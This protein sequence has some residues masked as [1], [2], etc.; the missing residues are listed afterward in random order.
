M[1]GD[2]PVCGP[3]LRLALTTCA[4]VT[5]SAVDIPPPMDRFDGKVQAS[6]DGVVVTACQDG[7][8]AAAA[9]MR[10]G[11]LLLAIDGWRVQDV[12]EVM[13]ALRRTADPPLLGHVALLRDG[14]LVEVDL[15]G[16]AAAG[17][18]GAALVVAKLEV[19][20]GKR[21]HDL[22]VQLSS[23]EAD[24][25]DH[26]P[27]RASHA[28]REW[29][30]AR[31]G[32]PGELGWAR[33]FADDFLRI[34]HGE[35]ALA[36]TAVAMPVPLLARLDR[37][38]HAIGAARGPHGG[39]PDPAALGED[40]RFVAE[41]YPFPWTPM[42]AM[43]RIA[44]QDAALAE[45]LASEREDP[46]GSGEERARQ[47]QGVVNQLAIKSPQDYLGEV[48]ASLM[49]ELHHGGWPYRSVL[50][51]AEQDRTRMVDWLRAQLAGPRAGDDL[52]SYALLGPLAVDGKIDE[53]A[54]IIA[55]LDSR[56][57]YLA[58]RALRMVRNAASTRNPAALPQ[59]DA[60][61]SQ[62]RARAAPTAIAAYDYCLKRSR[63][64]SQAVAQ[65]LDYNERFGV[66]ALF[67]MRPDLVCQSLLPD[68]AA[69]SGARWESALMCR[70]ICRLA[71]S[72][73]ADPALTDAEQAREL[74]EQARQAG[75]GCSMP[76][77]AR[78]SPPAGRARAT[79]PRRSAGWPRRSPCRA[80]RPITPRPWA[81]G[82]R[83][84]RCTMPPTMASRSRARR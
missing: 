12:G 46:A 8:P 20:L 36:P 61:I 27:L 82:C 35:G 56:S 53:A 43:G 62:S 23:E 65:P 55:D 5:A 13:L 25:L 67:K 58:W 68:A 44:T 31:Q 1:R 64:L 15:H 41:F 76:T 18:M 17:K 34:L 29:A 66:P 42:P 57:P 54:R 37:L 33:H 78:S 79:S 80:A 22:G 48:E 26:I 3:L 81:S 47:A 63:E 16:L 72:F 77:S 11:D 83:S 69:T 19:G 32:A 50:V 52:L 40:P 2:H 73:A 39:D 7:L 30:D 38:Y 84:T 75:A 28:L 59:V 9:G 6:M 60:L 71:W 4:W 45:T 74:A 21:L 51:W 14:Q 10:A 70:T 24:A 49:D